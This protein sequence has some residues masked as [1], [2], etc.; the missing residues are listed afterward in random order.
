M[1][2]QAWGRVLER[3]VSVAPCPGVRVTLLPPPWTEQKLGAM[4]CEEPRDELTELQVGYALTL[5]PTGR[6]TWG[7]TA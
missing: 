4:Q 7:C 3:G 5:W 1:W 2:L 6:N